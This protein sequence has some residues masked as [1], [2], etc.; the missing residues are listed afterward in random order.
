[1]VPISINKCYYKLRYTTL[2]LMVTSKSREEME[3][4]YKKTVTE[5]RTTRSVADIS[6][7][8]EVSPEGYFVILENTSLSHDEHIGEWSIKSRSSSHY[9]VVYTLPPGFVLYPQK[10]VTVRPRCY[11]NSLFIE[12]YRFYN[13]GESINFTST[14]IFYVLQIYARGRGHSVPPESLVFEAEESFATGSDVH[15]HLYNKSGEILY[16]EI[17]LYLFDPKGYEDFLNDR[18]LNHSALRRLLKCLYL[19]RASLLQ[20]SSTY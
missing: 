14:D 12:I 17:D 5:I 20:R 13:L 19:E 8:V 2:E 7:I 6:N 15:T 9:E 16:L 4:W 3:M 11:L 1:M 18:Q 10:K